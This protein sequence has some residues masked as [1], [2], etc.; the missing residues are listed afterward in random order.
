[1]DGCL[2]RPPALVSVW[3]QM[4]GDP[5]VAYPYR[6]VFDIGAHKGNEVLEERGLVLKLEVCSVEES[7]LGFCI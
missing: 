4:G 6:K 7:E 2:L 3:P 5:A 1:M